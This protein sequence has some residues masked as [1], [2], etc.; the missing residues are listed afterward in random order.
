M[1]D[2]TRFPRLSKDEP[3]AERWKHARTIST[4]RHVDG[5][6]GKAVANRMRMALKPD[7]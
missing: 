2:R 5:V 7:G 6:Q 3:R 1:P 4:L